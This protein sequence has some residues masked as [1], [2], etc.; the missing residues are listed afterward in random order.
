MYLWVFYMSS[1]CTEYACSEISAAFSAHALM[2]AADGPS[3]KREEVFEVSFF[4]FLLLTKDTVFQWYIYY[5]YPWCEV[6]SDSGWEVVFSKQG[7]A[8]W[9]SSCQ[10]DLQQC[11]HH[12]TPQGAPRPWDILGGIHR[13]KS[14]WKK[15][16]LPLLV[17]VSFKMLCYDNSTVHIV[18]NTRN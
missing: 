18:V 6:F 13:C 1:H 15:L 10:H 16:P 14:F 5:P 9:G 11:I 3:E 17:L 4:Q 12:H 2:R 8:V 7:A